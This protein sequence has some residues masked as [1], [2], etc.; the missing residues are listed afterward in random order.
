MIPSPDGLESVGNFR[1]VNA[2]RDPRRISLDE[3]REDEIKARQVQCLHDNRGDGLFET[4][5]KALHGQRFPMPPISFLNRSYCILVLEKGPVPPMGAMTCLGGSEGP[6]G[7]KEP[8]MGGEGFRKQLKGSQKRL[9]INW[10]GLGA[11]C[12]RVHI[13]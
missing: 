10:E 5:A 7:L 2:S 4:V 1:L 8:W 6:E 11:N 13:G 9:R 12:L 3:V